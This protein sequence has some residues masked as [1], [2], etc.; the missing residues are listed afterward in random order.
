M[1]Y[2]FLLRGLRMTLKQQL[3]LRLEK[4]NQNESK[5]MLQGLIE[6]QGWKTV[7]ENLS[8]KY[9]YPVNTIK[10]FLKS[11]GFEP[12]R[13]DAQ[14]KRISTN[15]ERYGAGSKPR[16]P[17]VD[18]NLLYKY[19]VEDF[20]DL[21]EI[22]DLFDKKYTK[23]QIRDALGRYDIKR[24]KKDNP[25]YRWSD[26]SREKRKNTCVK[27]YGV[28]NPMK[29]SEV[30]QK[31]LTSRE[32][33]YGEDWGKQITEKARTT[34]FNKTGIANPFQDVENVENGRFLKYGVRK[35][36]D[37]P[38]VVEKRRETWQT[39][40][41]DDIA[42]KRLCDKREATLL[43]RYGDSHYCNHEKTV[44]TCRQK[45]GVDYAVL[46]PAANNKHKVNSAPNER[47]HKLLIEHGLVEGEGFFREF[48]V[49]GKQFDF[50]IGNYL[51]EIDPAVTHNST[52]N[53]WIKG[54]IDPYYH[55]LKSKIA[56]NN[57]YRCIHVFD[58]M[59]PEKIL[60][61]VINKEVPLKI[62]FEEP[63]V[64]YFSMKQKGLC[65]ENTPKR[66]VIYDDGSIEL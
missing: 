5:E 34:Y 48:L 2:L 8:K 54:G 61:D 21:Q 1:T 65:D 3:N 19:Y 40:F 11:N 27:R 17:E 28:D 58:W 59:D 35:A 44:N 9:D 41:S 47:F 39:H 43:M 29:N 46:L 53:P 57:G 37:I 63:R 52:W 64:H 56:F 26:S 62:T 60:V 20:K 51:I 4:L 23:S 14:L 18:R 22:V 13:S 45:Y 12:P 49:E 15:L 36:G 30:L 32:Q 33:I 25:N 6:E 55:Q 31:S 7:I 24:N 50:K 66:V 38:G 16:K 10:I 42:L